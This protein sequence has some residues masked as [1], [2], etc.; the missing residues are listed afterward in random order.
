[1]ADYL[2]R[3]KITHT[4]KT[5]EQLYKMQYYVYE[6]P[7]MILRAVIGFG[8]VVAAVA[9]AIPTWGKALLLLLGAWLLVSRDFPAAVRADR[10]L[11]E[12]R[13]KLPDMSYGFGND[14]VHLTGEGSMDLPYKKLTRLVEDRQYLYLFVNR[15][16]VCMMEKA[17]V[18]PD[19]IMAFA[20]FMEE[21]TGLTWRAEKSFLSM[22]IYDLRQAFKDM[23]G[24]K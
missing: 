12:R 7:R 17:S 13:A 5:V 20:K 22:S 1:M 21:K 8:L 18:K 9:A 10:A 6:K 11:S 14:K 24:K 15:N 2:Y 19:D 4:E 16:S 23:R 3:A